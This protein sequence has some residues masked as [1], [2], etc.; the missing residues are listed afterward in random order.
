MTIHSFINDSL[1]KDR[2][3]RLQVDP[4]EIEKLGE[5]DGRIAAW[6]LLGKAFEIKSKTEFE[7]YVHECATH[8]QDGPVSLNNLPAGYSKGYFDGRSAV[9]TEFDAL[10]QEHRFEPTHDEI[11]QSM[12][13][14]DELDLHLYHNRS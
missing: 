14:A 10:V 5:A 1:N 11:A 7:K 13:F 9:F 12:G 4:T 3:A 2:A 8:Y 6:E